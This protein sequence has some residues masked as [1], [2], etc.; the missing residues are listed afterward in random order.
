MFDLNI[1]IVNK[2]FSW[3]LQKKT[4]V[5]SCVNVRKNEALFLI[6]FSKMQLMR[7]CKAIHSYQA[8]RF[9]I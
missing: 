8:F 1:N 9:S 4:D 7:V 3:Q 6:Q 2:S 5:Q